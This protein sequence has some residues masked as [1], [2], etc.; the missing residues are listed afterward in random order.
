VRVDVYVSGKLK[1][2]R[3]GRNIARVTLRRLPRA[4][5]TVKVVA[6]HSNGSKLISTRTYRGCTKSRPRVRGH[7]H[8]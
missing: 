6:T 2:S 1:V 4:R 8:R 5:F 3:R 7:H